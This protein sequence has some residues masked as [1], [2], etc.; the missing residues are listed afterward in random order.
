MAIAANP[1]VGMVAG[2]AIYWN[3]W[4]SGQDTAVPSGHLQDL[5]INPPDASLALYPLG[6]A[7]T[8]CPSDFVLHADLVR[9]IGG[10]EEQFIGEKLLYEDQAFLAKLFL[11]APVY[12]CSAPSIKYR[13]HPD[14]CVSRATTNMEKYHEI[15]LYFLEWF[16]EYL[17]KNGYPD[18]RL[19]SGLQRVLRYYRRPRIDYLLSLPTKVRNRVRRILSKS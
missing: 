8:P 3:S 10:F 14:S 15:R 6:A 18:P 7:E 11:V 16:E 1:K 9:Q 13:I 5:V 19:A 12:F 17:K 4:S 2:T